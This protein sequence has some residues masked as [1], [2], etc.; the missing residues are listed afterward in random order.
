MR[1]KR[2]IISSAPGR[3]G[4]IG[5]PTDM[6]GGAVLSCSVPMRARVRLTPADNLTLCTNSATCEIREWRDLRPRG[7]VFDVARAVLTYLR[8]PPIRCCVEYESEI[9]LRSGLAGSTALVVALL[10]GL[11]AWM[12]VHL[13]RYQLAEKARFVEL[14]HL[15][16]V[17]GYQDAYMCTFGGLNY[18]DFRGKQF[19]R[20]EEAELFAT[21]EPI[22]VYVRRLPFVLGFTGVQHSSGAVHKPLRERWLEGDPQVVEGYERITELARIGKR[23][24]LLEDWDLLARAM[25]ENHAIQRDLGGS[26]ESNERLIAAALAAG[27]PAAKLAGA[28]DGGTIIALWLDEDTAPLE[29]ALRAAGAQAIYRPEPVIGATLEEEE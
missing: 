20:A 12:G 25:N 7:D 8:L 9:P 22:A 18:M 6:Y 15:K 13:N 14:H 4:V 19:Y 1:S 2:Q 21:I 17:C 28:G 11:L 5:N 27:A 10:Q 16:V 29:K 24:L 23:A 26:G 3:A